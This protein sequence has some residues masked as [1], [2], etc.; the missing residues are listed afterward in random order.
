MSTVQTPKIFILQW[1][2]W[3]KTDKQ[4]IVVA[5]NTIDCIQSNVPRFIN[6][7]FC[8]QNASFTSCFIQQTADYQHRLT[9]LMCNLVQ[10]SFQ[11]STCCRDRQQLR[12]NCTEHLLNIYTY[13]Q[14][15]RIW[16]TSF[17]G[18]FSQLPPNRDEKLGER[19]AT[20]ARRDHET[21]RTQDRQTFQQW[22]VALILNIRRESIMFSF[23][24]KDK[25]AL[26]RQQPPAEPQTSPTRQTSMLPSCNG[27]VLTT[28]QSRGNMFSACACERFTSQQAAPHHGLP[29][30]RGSGAIAD[31]GPTETS[32][33]G[34]L[35]LIPA[36][37][38]RRPILTGSL[39]APLI[40][41][42]RR[43]LNPR[44][45]IREGIDS[46]SLSFSLSSTSS[47]SSPLIHLCSVFPLFPH[48]HPLLAVSTSSG[49]RKL[50][51]H[52]DAWG[53]SP[54]GGVCCDAAHRTDRLLRERR[55]SNSC[56]SARKFCTVGQEI[57]EFIQKCKYINVASFRFRVNLTHA[58]QN[59]FLIESDLCTL[60]LSW[61]V[62]RWMIFIF[63]QFAYYLC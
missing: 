35:H 58:Q 53:W 49:L 57:R 28:A 7:I 20:N 29:V 55:S 2:R 26:K 5:L 50:C 19:T 45:E 25:S 63:L 61:R 15:R 4:K 48:H 9:W 1:N 13:N 10:I 14:I 31:P 42:E 27:P 62:A 54:I 43:F 24:R 17:T 32:S 6:R 3:Y 39:A 33:P 46:L 52:G 16:F 12:L 60:L 38:C 11:I 30:G 34:F 23:K 44:C 56:S 21:C 40:G 51:Y 18:W 8:P 22:S 37:V 41:K 36:L 59:V 47:F